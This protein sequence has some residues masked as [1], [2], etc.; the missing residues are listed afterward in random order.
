M[1]TPH[2]WN[3]GPPSDRNFDPHIMI[4][5][6]GLFGLPPAF[7]LL[8]L[9][10]YMTMKMEVICSSEKSVDFQ[11]TTRRYIP[12]DSTRLVRLILAK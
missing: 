8:F 6:N 4:Q 5:P 1:G 12:V 10:A 7:M 11:R 3:Q 2:L 9:S